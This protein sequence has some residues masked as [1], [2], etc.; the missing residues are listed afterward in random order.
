MWKERKDLLLRVSKDYDIFF[1]KCIGP[2]FV[3]RE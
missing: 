3:E 2:E 1:E